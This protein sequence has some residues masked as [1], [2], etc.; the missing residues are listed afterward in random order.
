MQQAPVMGMTG[1]VICGDCRD[2]M[3][4][5]PAESVNLIITSPPYFNI[6]KYSDDNSQIGNIGDFGAYINGMLPAWQE[7]ERVLAPNGK[8]AIN[9]PLMPMPK[10]DMQTHHNRHI[11]DIHS[12]IQ[13]SIITHTGL[14]LMDVYIWDRTNSTRA[15]MFGSYPYP[16][17]FY[18]Q[19][20]TEFVAIYVKDGKPAKRNEA[21]KERSKLSQAEWLAYTKQVWGIPVPNKSNDAYGLHPALMPEEIATRCIRLF[22][23][24]GDVVLDPFC[25][26]GTTLKAAAKLGRRYIGIDISEEY[27]RISQTRLSKIQKTLDVVT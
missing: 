4:G 5:M 6:K 9:A 17:N 24:A 12:T 15:P 26:S 16:S 18:S 11:Y 27:C 1:K 14:Y 19:N 20:T 7:C 25:G 13:Q 8:I 10:K 23:F 22:S 2:S 3:S 21:A